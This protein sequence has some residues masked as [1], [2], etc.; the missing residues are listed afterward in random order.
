[1]NATRTPGIQDAKAGPATGRPDDS[2]LKVPAAAE[3]IGH[4]LRRA[5]IEKMARRAAHPGLYR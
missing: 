4:V 1:M 3:D 2:D 5:T